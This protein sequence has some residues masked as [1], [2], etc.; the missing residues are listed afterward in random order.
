M[1]PL[2]IKSLSMLL[3]ACLLL[4]SASSEARKPH[5]LID[6]F[7]QWLHQ[8]TSQFDYYLLALSWSPA[9][10]NSAAGHKADKQLQCSTPM[11]FVVHGLWPQYNNNDYPHDCGPVADVPAAV[12]AIAQHANPP[13]PPGDPQLVN[14]EWSKHGTCSGLNM[15]EYFTAIKT[16]AEKLKIPEIFKAPQNS[17]NLDAAAITT[18]FTSINPGLS[19]E[20]I[21]IETDHQGNISGIQVCFSKQLVFQPCTTKHSKP[22]GGIILPVEHQP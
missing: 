16:S 8:Q 6:D 4:F 21:H 20:M 22:E 5:S 18:A 17:L 14:H 12:A 1:K 19:A 10:C 11:G 9:F 15:Q 7:S 13:M 2:Y 3:G